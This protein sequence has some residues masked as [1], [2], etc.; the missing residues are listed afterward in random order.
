[1][2]YFPQLPLKKAENSSETF[3]NKSLF[4]FEKERKKSTKQPFIARVSRKSSRKLLLEKFFFF[5]LPIKNTLSCGR[6]MWRM[7]N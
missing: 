6:S 1:M 7:S 2:I 4:A 5:C 3:R